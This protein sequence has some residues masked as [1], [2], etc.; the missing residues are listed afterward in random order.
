[1]HAL[2]AEHETAGSEPF[3]TTGFG[4]SWTVQ[5][6]VAP[7]P[8][9]PSVRAHTT[10]QAMQIARRF[11]TILTHLREVDAPRAAAEPE[12]PNR[13]RTGRGQ[14][15]A[16]NRPTSARRTKPLIVGLAGCMN[17]CT[18]DS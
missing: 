8:A 16:T 14:A 12:R 13:I 15:D 11:I 17:S 3:V 6:E 9:T 4:V 7:A 5:D 1:M 10:Q 18:M 2:A